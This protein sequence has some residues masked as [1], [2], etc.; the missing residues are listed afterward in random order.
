MAKAKVFF[1]KRTDQS[2]AKARI[3]TKYLPAWAHVVK[4]KAER[5]SGGRI[6]YIDL[7]SGPGRYE[8]GEASTPILVLEQAISQLHLRNHLITVFN[9][10]TPKHVA[11]LE[12]AV[13]D[14]PGIQSLTHTPQITNHEVGDET[15]KFLEKT[16]LPPTFLF[17]DPYGYK[18]LSL[19][20]IHAAIKDWGC[21]CLFFFN[22]NRIRGALLNDLVEGHIDDLFGQARAN[23][24]RA[25]IAAMPKREKEEAV[26]ESLTRAIQ[27]VG[28]GYVV[29]FRFLKNRGRQT[30]HHLIFVSKHPKGYEIMKDIMAAESSFCEQGVPSYTFWPTDEMAPTLGLERPLLD[31]LEA[32]LPGHFA[33]SCLAMKDVFEAHHIGKPYV[34]RNYK[35]AL[36]NLEARGAVKVSPPAEKRRRGKDGKL[37]FS[38]DAL[39]TF[40]T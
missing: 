13:A 21:D 27:D 8:D 3:V 1:E 17:A 14:L 30:S 40:P 24:L 7:F 22:Y 34:K 5:H 18:G 19:R 26:I 35:E 10:A 6:A 16:A 32:M 25:R 33:G 9:D 36:R 11:A 4:A 28:G 38:D 15:V 2:R 12:M 20:L 31:E 37:S 39:V 29:S 23:E